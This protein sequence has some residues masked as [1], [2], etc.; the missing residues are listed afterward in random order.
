MM[1]HGS[2][3]QERLIPATRAG[4]NEYI[5]LLEDIRDWTSINVD[6]YI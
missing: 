4:K 5:F 6:I 3:L 2:S 1:N